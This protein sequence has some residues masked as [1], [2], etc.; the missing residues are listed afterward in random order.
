MFA[1]KP[2]DMSAW[3]F[4]VEQ[5]CALVDVTDQQDLVRLAVS[6]LEKDALT[7]WRA[8]FAAHEHALEPGHQYALTWD[9]FKDC[10]AEAFE[11]VD[12]ELKLRRKLSTL[13]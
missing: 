3:L 13:R 10:I 4:S 9:D 8:Y 5:Y 1:G 6:R 11:D 7:W 2:S 12:R